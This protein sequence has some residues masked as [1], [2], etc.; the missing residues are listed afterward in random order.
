MFMAVALPTPDLARTLSVI[1][2][3]LCRATAARI[4]DDR[5][6]GPILILIVGRLRR[7]GARFASLA[8]RVEARRL[9]VRRVAARPVAAGL[10]EPRPAAVATQR[11]RRRPDLPHSF[12]WL[13]RL[14]PGTAAYAGQ[15]QSLLADPQTAALLAA[16][17]QAGRILRPLCRMLA[18]P[19]PDQLRLLPGP[20]SGPPQ[21]G[22][23]T[24]EPPLEPPPTRPER[25]A[26]P[27]CPARLIPCREAAA[28]RKP[29]P[30]D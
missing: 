11:I 13:I 15:V 29:P 28:G 14:V 8:A 1:I 26:R 24:A 5:F 22:A 20:D 27:V 16:A 9:A 30:P 4:A 10:A 3:G 18:I 23:D 17:P 12:A 7:L 6:A 19:L 2:D 21:A 25:S